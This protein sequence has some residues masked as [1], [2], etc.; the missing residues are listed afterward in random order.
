MLSSTGLGDAV[1]SDE[2]RGGMRSGSRGGGGE[3]ELG[4]LLGGRQ[5]GVGKIDNKV[6]R[7]TEKGIRS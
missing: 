7:R 4:R 2:G 1:A 5:V 3:T 6:L